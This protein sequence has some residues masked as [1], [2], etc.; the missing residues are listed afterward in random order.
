[1][2]DHNSDTATVDLTV[3]SQDY[4]PIT[5][6]PPE[7]HYATQFDTIAK[8]ADDT[9]FFVAYNQG[10]QKRILHPLRLG[11]GLSLK[12]Q[13]PF[14]Q[15]ATFLTNGTTSIFDLVLEKFSDDP[16][17]IHLL[18]QQQGFSGESCLMEQQAIDKLVEELQELGRMLPT[19]TLNIRT[20]FLPPPPPN[21]PPGSRT[22][23]LTGDLVD[24]NVVAIDG[25]RILRIN[26]DDVWR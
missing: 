24:R 15:E 20:C 22:I 11:D 18:L 2:A 8:C 26:K 17:S 7:I 4:F 19:I 5:V 13:R 3:K 1:M 16:P 9:I 25:H 6:S 12:K 21:K 23:E 14:L 10:Y